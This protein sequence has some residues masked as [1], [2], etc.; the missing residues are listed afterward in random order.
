MLTLTEGTLEWKTKIRYEFFE[1]GTDNNA[2]RPRWVRVGKSWFCNFPPGWQRAES[3]NMLLRWNPFQKGWRPFTL[4]LL[5]NQLRIE[6]VFIFSAIKRKVML[7]TEMLTDSA[8]ITTWDRHEQEKPVYCWLQ[9][10]VVITTSENLQRTDAILSHCAVQLQ[11]W[12][13]KPSSFVYFTIVFF[14]SGLKQETGKQ[15][16]EFPSAGRRHFPL[17]NS[18]RKGNLLW[19]LLPLILENN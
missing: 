6:S 11:S 5:P 10:L 17:M 19:P 4:F 2:R 3:M 13:L 1:G 16:R 8:V 14:F 12:K 18:M 9:P 7:Y 15:K